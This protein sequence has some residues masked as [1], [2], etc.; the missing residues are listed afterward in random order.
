MS[1]MKSTVVIG[2]PL[3]EVFGF[4]LALDESAPTIDDPSAQVGSVI[5]TPGGPSGP[6]TTFRSHQPNLVRPGKR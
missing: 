6:G 3:E 2:R 5:K 4:F 1:K